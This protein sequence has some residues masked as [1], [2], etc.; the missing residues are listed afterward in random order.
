MSFVEQ[1]STMSIQKQCKL[2]SVPRSSYYHKPQRKVCELNEMLMQAI[3]RIYMEEPTYGSRRIRDELRKLGYK[4]GRKR[5]RRLMQVMGIEPIY[6]KPR[7]SIPGKGHKK[8]PYLLRNLDITRSNQVWCT[9]ITYIPIGN[10][11]VY[12]TAVMDWSSRYVISWRLSNSMDDSFCIECLKDALQ[13]EGIP[14]IFNTDQG[15]QFTGKDF[16]GV[17]KAHEIKISMDGKGRAL[18]NVMI[19]R[20]WRTVKY[21]DIYIRGYETMGELYQGL[22][23][24]FQK[25]NTRKHQTLGMSPEEK[26]RSGFVMEDA[27]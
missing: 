6:S 9:D 2:L 10:G 20:L 12:L 1:G 26:Y 16:T 24:F 4:V 11:H 3:D 18:D 19:E 8:Y 13:A 23:T 27:A 17:L 25:Y 22:S 15:S 7:L 5:V 21:D 14:E